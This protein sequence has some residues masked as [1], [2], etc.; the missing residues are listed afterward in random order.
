[1]DLTGS[2]TN[3]TLFAVAIQFVSESISTKDIY[4]IINL[5]DNAS[6]NSNF[7]I[8]NLV[9]SYTPTPT[10][11]AK[12]VSANIK[13]FLNPGKDTIQGIRAEAE[14]LSEMTIAA[15]LSPWEAVIAQ[16]LFRLTK[17]HHLREAKEAWRNLKAT[18]KTRPTRNFQLNK[19]ASVEHFNTDILEAL[20]PHLNKHRPSFRKLDIFLENNRTLRHHGGPGEQ[21]PSLLG[22][23]ERLETV[24][25]VYNYALFEPVCS[26]SLHSA[27]EKFLRLC[28][29]YW[30]LSTPFQSIPKCHC[31]FS[32][33]NF[34]P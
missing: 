9:F 2:K 17:G 34:E 28:I 22:I 6:V 31:T 21:Y 20:M 13:F 14:S 15:K 5:N 12:Q 32:E 24:A 8:N 33:A 29:E 10:L 26:S 3:Y 19:L 25:Q 18:I 27:D 30:F 16:V 11:T 4:V 7:T 23:Y 1:L